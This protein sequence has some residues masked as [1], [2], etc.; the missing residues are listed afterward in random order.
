M[1]E[2]RRLNV[3]DACNLQS[4]LLVMRLTAMGASLRSHVDESR[5]AAGPTPDFATGITG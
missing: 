2:R 3:S 1:R 5:T 4:Q